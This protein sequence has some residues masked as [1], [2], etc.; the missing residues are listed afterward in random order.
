ML[1]RRLPPSDEQ[2]G[3]DPPYFL[4]SRLIGNFAQQSAD[5]IHFSGDRIEKPLLFAAF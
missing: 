3:S 4:K 5:H 1:A 2:T